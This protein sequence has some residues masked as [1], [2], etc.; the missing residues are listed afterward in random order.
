[1]LGSIAAE[2]RSQPLRSPFLQS[3]LSI[4]TVDALAARKFIQ[5]RHAIA[6]TFG[7]KLRSHPATDVP[8]LVGEQFLECIASGNSLVVQLTPCR[9]HLAVQTVVFSSKLSEVALL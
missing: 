7:E 9:R 3:H 6:I 1:M 2:R 4:E 5:N 8:R